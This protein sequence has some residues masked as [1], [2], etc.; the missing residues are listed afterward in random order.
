MLKGLNMDDRTNKNSQKILDIIYKAI[1]A[2]NDTLPHDRK[3]EKSPEAGLFNDLGAVDSLGLTLMIVDL[4][5]KIEEDLGVR[6]T[7][8]NNDTLSQEDSPFNNVSALAQY[9]ESMID[10]QNG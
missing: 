2:L 3:V 1:D 6:L 7:L 4:E 5:Q 8:V 9:I 10:A